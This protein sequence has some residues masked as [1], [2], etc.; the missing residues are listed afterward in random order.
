MATGT[1]RFRPRPIDYD[2]PLP[3]VR[4]QNELE[5]N[6]DGNLVPKKDILTESI[7]D[8]DEVKIAALFSWKEIRCD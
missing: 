4:S 2:R 3:V 6:D 7:D 8:V 1:S 5:L